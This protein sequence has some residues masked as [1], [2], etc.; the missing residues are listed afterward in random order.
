MSICLALEQENL[1]SYL[2][3]FKIQNHKFWL[4]LNVPVFLNI[5]KSHIHLITID[6]NIL[7]DRLEKF[8]EVK[9]W[10]A[11]GLGLI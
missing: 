8:V 1:Q 2:L 6:Y 11:P 4:L 7:L 9:E 3:A 5:H 10:P